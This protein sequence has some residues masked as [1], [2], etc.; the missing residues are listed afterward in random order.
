MNLKKII[1]YGLVIFYLQPA[2]A[3]VP[4]TTDARIK[5]LVYN[6][7]EVFRLKFHYNYQSYIELSED[8]K[9]EILSVGD[10]YSWQINPADNRIFIKPLEAGV[11]TNMT[12]ITNRRNYH[13]EIIS[14]DSNESEG[15]EELVYVARFFYPDTTYDYLQAIRV[16]K[17]YEATELK[18]LATP[19]ITGNAT[20]S[21][22]A[23]PL[24][25]ANIVAANDV[26]PVS[27]AL[28]PIPPR[29][30]EARPEPWEPPPQRDGLNYKYSLVGPESEVTPGKVYDDGRYTYFEFPTGNIPDIFYVNADGSETPVRYDLQDGVVVVDSI[31][32]QFSIRKGTRLNCIFNES[33]I[34]F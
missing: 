33:K 2:F 34:Y 26:R 11:K 15:D 31:S 21:K 17:P 6:E 25:P 8:E 13:F 27:S 28:P 16:K 19:V 30:L 24:P 23:A 3:L 14:S 12:L 7:N 22:I 5:T 10:N 29:V 20:E 18:V 9:I 4:I 32:W 1:F